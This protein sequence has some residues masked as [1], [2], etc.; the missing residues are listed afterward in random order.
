MITLS[1]IA[2]RRAAFVIGLIGVMLTAR[3]AMQ[4]VAMQ[5]YSASDKIASLERAS[6]ADPGSYRI[7]MRLADAYSARRTCDLVKKHAA[8][9]QHLFPNA[10][11]P[12][13]FLARC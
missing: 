6:S 9:A 8:A 11:A 13:R 10:P 3:G 4:I 1:P 2:S 12:R 5:R 7:H